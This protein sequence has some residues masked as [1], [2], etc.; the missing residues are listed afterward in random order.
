MM[1]FRVV[2]WF[3]LIPALMVLSSQS[4]DLEATTAANTLSVVLQPPEHNWRRTN[5][6]MVQQQHQQLIMNDVI[7]LI[8]TAQSSLNS[9][10]QDGSRMLQ[11]QSC[12]ST[13]G[14]N[15]CVLQTPEKICESYNNQTALTCTC[16]RYGTKDTQVDC[17]YNTPQCNADNTL[18]YSLS[19]SQIFDVLLQ[20]R[21]VTT[22]TTYLQSSI[23]TIPLNTELCIRIFPTENGNYESLANCSTSLQPESSAEAKVCNSCSICT[24]A[25]NRIIV[26]S[27]Q[28]VAV[29]QPIV[30]LL[31]KI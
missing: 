29:I 14:E 8:T 2:S 21:V 11:D 7:E 1:F 16:S 25:L 3:S 20:S 27:Q 19:I 5:Q 15:A 4:S 31:V 6:H 26:Q 17:S 22:C 13:E 18:C 28:V 12:N 24:A 10:S 30:V 9:L 23:T